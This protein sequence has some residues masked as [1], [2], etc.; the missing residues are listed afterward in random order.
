ME[1]YYFVIKWN[2]VFLCNLNLRSC[3]KCNLQ[4]LCSTIWVLKLQ[5]FTCFMH[6]KTLK[7]TIWIHIGIWCSSKTETSI[8][9]AWWWPDI[10]VKTYSV[11]S[12]IKTNVCALVFVLFL[13]NCCV[14]CSFIHIIYY[15]KYN[16]MHTIKIVSDIICL[17]KCTLFILQKNRTKGSL[18]FGV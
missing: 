9:Y 18:V 16:R 3:F 4:Y 14:D 12:K 17:C 7:N 15:I 5:L 10:S 13:T 2:N 6:F 8:L 1:I 11:N